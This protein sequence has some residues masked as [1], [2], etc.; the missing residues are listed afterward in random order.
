[1]RHLI[2]EEPVSRS[3]VWSVRLAWF[4]LAVTLVAVALLRFGSVELTP[5]LVALGAGLSFALTA[6][7]LALLAFIRIWTEGRRGFGRAVW[8]LVLALAIL[9]YPGW[10]ILRALTL[11]ALT[12]IPPALE[13]PPAFSRSR[14]A[15]AARGGW[16]PPDVPP[17]KRQ[18]QRD[19]YP[20]IAP[21]S[22]D[23]PPY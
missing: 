5:G 12:D 19:A 13:T 1:M 11:P 15:L 21:L 17:E 7:V 8:G 3:A 23:I 6:A 10:F 4:G 2:L 18:K 20:R 22:L 9:G 16:V 14:D